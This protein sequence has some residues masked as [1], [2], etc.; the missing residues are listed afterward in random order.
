MSESKLRPPLPPPLTHD[1]IRFILAS[2]RSSTS[3]LS[4]EIVA[5][6]GAALELI[7]PKGD[8]AVDSSGT[9]VQIQSRFNAGEIPSLWRQ[10]GLLTG[11]DRSPR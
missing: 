4:P 8:L 7:L 9:I 5:A 6:I 3:D 11:I 1:G 2:P 10:A